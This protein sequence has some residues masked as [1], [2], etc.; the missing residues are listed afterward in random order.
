MK[1]ANR[2]AY[3]VEVNGNGEGLQTSDHSGMATGLTKR[4]YFAA[5]AMQGII[6]GFT[7]EDMC[8]E[9]IKSTWL[10]LVNLEVSI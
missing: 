1:N 3:P 6:A 9:R 4:E 2:P 7:N 5:I 10:R 8:N